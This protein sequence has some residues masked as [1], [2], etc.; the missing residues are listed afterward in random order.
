M[1]AIKPYLNQ[2]YEE[3]KQSCQQSGKLFKD[4]SFPANDTSLYRFNEKKGIAWKRPHE[5][6]E[7]PKFIVDT[8]EPNDLDQGQIGDWYY[9][10]F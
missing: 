1:S 2:S 9:I 3:I 7:N 6:V 10:H 5:I 8:I 4:K